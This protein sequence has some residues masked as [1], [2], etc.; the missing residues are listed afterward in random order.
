M[1]ANPH[2][3]N[4]ADRERLAAECYA[5]VKC[6]VV[7]LAAKSKRPPVLE[8]GKCK[9]WKDVSVSLDDLFDHIRNGG[10]YGIQTGAPSGLD[11]LDIDQPDLH[12]V[13]VDRLKAY[14][15][16]TETGRGMHFW[17]RH[18]ARVCK[19]K[20]K[21][22]AGIDVKTSGGYVVAPGSVHENGKEYVL[23]GALEEAPSW[24]ENLL[25]ILFPDTPGG[26]PVSNLPAPL[27]PDS[28]TP[29]AAK[30][31]E[32]A[33]DTV[34]TAPEGQRNDTLNRE[35]FGLGGLFHL[36]LDRRDVEEALVQAALSAELSEGEA[37]ATF[38]SGWEKGVM[39]P[40]TIEN[41][42]GHK[43]SSSYTGSS[44][45]TDA[46]VAK[47]HEYSETQRYWTSDNEVFVLDEKHCVHTNNTDFDVSQGVRAVLAYNKKAIADATKGYKHCEPAPVFNR[48]GLMVHMS[49]DRSKLRNTGRPLFD[50]V[51]DGK[52]ARWFAIAD[53]EAQRNA[54]EGLLA[55]KK[56]IPRHHVSPGVSAKL[57]E[58]SDGLPYISKIVN[59]PIFLPDGTLTRKTGYYTNPG[60][61]V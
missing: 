30:A 20:S 26:S 49:P 22:I 27:P 16:W 35:A 59:S 31:L 52:A 10:N 11:V 58:S 53:K 42:G 48:G 15:P 32:S 9:R 3:L 36:G 17:F 43:N 50:T 2:K 60:N 4:N 7:L 45:D 51:L 5:A 6:A 61:L 37:R 18:H 55:V 23:Y 39:S 41:F 57:L 54:P 25:D 19:N 44:M 46:S 28:V 8:N 1:A 40:R 21:A 13:L 12:P 38:R 47:Q 14:A 56:S 24:P 33:I 29:Y 34:G